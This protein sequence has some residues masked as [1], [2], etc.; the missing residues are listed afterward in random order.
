MR[1]RQARLAVVFA[2]AFG[3]AGCSSDFGKFLPIDGRMLQEINSDVVIGAIYYE[4]TMKILFA[5]MT[6]RFRYRIFVFPKS[7]PLQL[8]SRA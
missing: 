2:V 7:T 3:L 5:T 4:D 8:L 6:S 1:T